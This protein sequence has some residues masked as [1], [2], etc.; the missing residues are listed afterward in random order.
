LRRD[1]DRPREGKTRGR[2]D[3]WAFGGR[4]FREEKASGETGHNKPGILHSKVLI[5]WLMVYEIFFNDTGLWSGVTGFEK[6]R[7]G[8]SAA[9]I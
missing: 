5:E 8:R 3:R 4:S 9:E 1:R 7:F 2:R 6:G